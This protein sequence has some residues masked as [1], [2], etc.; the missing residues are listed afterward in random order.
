[1]GAVINEAA[2]EITTL[3]ARVEK[4]ETELFLWRNGILRPTG[5]QVAFQKDHDEDREGLHR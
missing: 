1:M 5:E 3:R 2:A 4:L